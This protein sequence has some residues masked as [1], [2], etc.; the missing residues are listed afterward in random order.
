MRHIHLAFFQALQ[1]VVGRQ[2]DQLDIQVAARFGKPGDPFAVA[3][4]EDEDFGAIATVKAGRLLFVRAGQA[5]TASGQPLP[6]LTLRS[7]GT[8][9]LQPNYT[10]LAA[11]R[12]QTVTEQVEAEVYA[13]ASE[14]LPAPG[15]AAE[16]FSLLGLR[17]DIRIH[18]HPQSRLPLRVSG[19]AGLFGTVTLNLEQARVD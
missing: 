7:V 10:Q 19:S 4:V 3:P 18:L 5:T 17:R 8:E 14:P 15:Q 2:V 12:E 9:P 16:P 1:Q 11:G 13:L 6:R